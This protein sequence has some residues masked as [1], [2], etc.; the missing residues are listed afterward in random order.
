MAMASG[1]SAEQLGHGAYY[2]VPPGRWSE[3]WPSVGPRL[4]EL[5]RRLDDVLAGEG[6]R[7]LAPAELALELHGAAAELF[8]LLAPEEHDLRQMITTLRT[9]FALCWDMYSYDETGRVSVQAHMDRLK[10]Q[11]VELEAELRQVQGAA[12]E[13]GGDE[14]ER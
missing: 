6:S 3:V 13:V 14:R 10:A 11:I 1:D 12:P 5:R 4:G 8:E 9:G 2:R 7:A